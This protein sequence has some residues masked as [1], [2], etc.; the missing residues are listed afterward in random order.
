MFGQYVALNGPGNAMAVVRAAGDWQVFDATFTQAT[1]GRNND[2]NTQDGGDGRNSGDD[3]E[4]D[5]MEWEARPSPPTMLGTNEQ[6][7]LAAQ[8]R[9]YLRQT[10]NQDRSS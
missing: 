2:T 7:S 9:R 1:V 4:D 6:R 3:G 10:N 8:N 5:T